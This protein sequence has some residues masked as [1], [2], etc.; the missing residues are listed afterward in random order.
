MAI[1]EPATIVS[2]PMPL[3]YDDNGGRRSMIDRRQFNY[4]AH[5]PERRSQPDRRTQED[6]RGGGH[7]QVTHQGGHPSTPSNV[8][9]FPA[10]RST[11]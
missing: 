3:T 1:Y 8:V 2:W 11:R 6:R 10:D 9:V 7:G 4:A 5:I